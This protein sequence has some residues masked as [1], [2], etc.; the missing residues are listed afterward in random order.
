M[1]ITTRRAAAAAMV[2]FAILAGQAASPLAHAADNSIP[3]IE[4]ALS[5]G[6]ISSDDIAPF[7]EIPGREGDQW[8][9]PPLQNVLAEHPTNTVGSDFIV[10]KDIDERKKNWATQ[11]SLY[12]QHRANKEVPNRKT[13]QDLKKWVDSYSTGMLNLGWCGGLSESSETFKSF[14]IEGNI[15]KILTPI[16]KA[17]YGAALPDSVTNLIKLFSQGKVGSESTKIVDYEN[18]GSQAQSIGFSLVEGAPLARTD[19]FISVDKSKVKGGILS[20]YLT[21]T[22]VDMYS[23]AY[24]GELNEA[25]YEQVASKV[26]EILGNNARDYVEEFSH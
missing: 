6:N 8:L 15:E 14:S 9:P 25:V 24:K 19:L 10:F 5:P 3:S 11:S 20:L 4:C 18:S 2:C 26:A 7:D 17:V 1:K 22:K 12:A 13:P 23:G 21:K 16:L